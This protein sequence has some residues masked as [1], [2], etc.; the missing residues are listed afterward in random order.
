MV[1]EQSGCVP[2]YVPGF[3]L[4][5]TAGLSDQLSDVKYLKDRYK[6]DSHFCLDYD[7]GLSIASVSSLPTFPLS[8]HP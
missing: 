7:I 1:S 5:G 2:S 6:S 3:I 4:H 8:P